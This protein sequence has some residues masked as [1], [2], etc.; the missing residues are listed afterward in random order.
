MRMKLYLSTLI[1]AAFVFSG[2]SATNGATIAGTSCTKAGAIK[3]VSKVKY[4]C[5]KSG[6]KL[7]WSKAQVS[8][9][10]PSSTPI[11]SKSPTPTEASTPSQTPSVTK[12]PTATPAPSLSATPSA[13]KTATPSTSA[14][15]SRIVLTT[16]EVAKHSEATSCWSI[17]YGNVY[18]LTKWIPKHPGGPAVIKAICGK[19]GTA[20]FEGQ[21]ANQGKPA[22]EIANYFLGKLGESV[23][24]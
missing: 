16:I 19:D 14:S 2:I 11:V 24:N 7:I 22:R 18:D 17:V 12:T 1:L 15:D 21:H 20:A 9:S 4:L 10:T 13:T 8:K 5:V 6:K 3:T 23:R